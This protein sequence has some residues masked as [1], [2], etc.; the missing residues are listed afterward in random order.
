M[1]PIITRFAPSPTGYL[2]VGGARTALYNWLYAR[3]NNGK[4]ILRIEDTDTQRSTTESS[5]AIFKALSWLGIDYDDGPYYQSDRLPLYQEKI[6]QLYEAGKIYPAFDTPEEL[7][8]IR[9][10]AM[11]EKRNPIYDRS[12]LRMSADEVSARMESGSAF[13]WR[14]KVPD[15]GITEVPDLLA[16]KSLTTSF[17][18]SSIGDFII[19]RP[20]TKN[21]PGMPLY[22]FVC[23]VDDAAMNISHVIRGNEHLTNAGRQVLLY[24]A[25]GLQIPQYVHLPIIMKNGKKMS[26]RDVDVDGQAPVSV[27]ER[28]A[29]GYLPEATLNHLVL[30]GWSHPDGKEIMDVEE[31]ISKFDLDRLSKSNANFDEK[32]YLFFNNHY[33]KE[34]SDEELLEL[35]KPYLIQAC[36]DL[37]HYSDPEMQKMIGLEK[38]HF[39]KLGE[40]PESLKFYFNEPSTYEQKGVEKDFMRQDYNAA[41]ILQFAMEAVKSINVFDTAEINRVLA[42]TVEKSE[43]PYKVFGPIVRLAITG[44]VSSPPIADVMEILGTARTITRIDR[45]IDSIGKMVPS[46]PP[47]ISGGIITN[48]I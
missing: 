39:R 44:R 28:A 32:K 15:E 36:L 14:F 42:E 17:A 18:N 13:V 8:I 30:L 1:K 35:A 33:I 26:K 6:N 40:I 38:K 20:G 27:L 21:N 22:N 29:L 46:M 41:S 47:L 12:A 4:F 7:E 23:A 37:T 10:L 34:K 43:V 2:H 48:D 25:M 45:A 31:M 5:D 16:G 11:Q 3:H 24:E 9:Q 19:T